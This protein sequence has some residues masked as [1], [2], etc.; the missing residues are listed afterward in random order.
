MDMITMD[1]VGFSSQ[2]SLECLHMLKNAAMHFRKTACEWITL[3]N[4][5][6]T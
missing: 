4:L 3:S 5:R 6:D 1:L 2:K